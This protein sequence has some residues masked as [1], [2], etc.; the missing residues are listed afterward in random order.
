MRSQS[1]TRAAA[2]VLAAALP[3]VGLVSLLLRRELDPHF[4]N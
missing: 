1:L 3:L 4:E 2:A